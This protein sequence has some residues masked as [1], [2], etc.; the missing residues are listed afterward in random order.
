MDMAQ[1]ELAGEA[2][3]AG[4][5]CPMHP[6][7]TS[8]RPDRCPK[9]G[10]KL[11]PAAL[12]KGHGADPHGAPHEH[13]G[14]EPADEHHGH[15]P[16]HEHHG[17][18]PA[19]GEHAS[20]HERGQGP[21]G[22]EWEDDMVEVNRLT[23]PANTRWKLVD[24]A[25]G[26]EGAAIDW[27]FQVGDRVKIR[28]VNEMDSDHPMHHPFHIHGAGRFLVLSRDGVVEPNLVWKDTVLVPTGQT[29]DLLHD[30]TNPGAWMAH[31]HISEHHES[32]MML[33]FRVDP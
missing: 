8:T 27:R 32:G 12:V 7:V 6:E 1:P 20:G 22:I 4:Y 24:R 14:H 10:M 17:Y 3:P 2:S 26:A 30:V 25:T 16:A 13:D 28:L 5:A 23:T 15:A 33:A 18:E 29:V 31:C 9:C 11:V 19:H 21:S